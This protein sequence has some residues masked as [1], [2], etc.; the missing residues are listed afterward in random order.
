MK[1][2]KRFFA[3]IL[4]LLILCSFSLQL[5]RPVMAANYHLSTT[6]NYL[7]GRGR[8][9]MS[10][11]TF[12]YTGSRVNG[13]NLHAEKYATG[14]CS[15]LK[16]MGNGPYAGQ[17]AFCIQPNRISRDGYA[18]R[19]VR[20][21][22]AIREIY[23]LGNREAERVEHRVGLIGYYGWNGPGV[24]RNDIS[25]VATAHL[26][27]D[28]LGWK[29]RQGAYY[30]PSAAVVARMNAIRKQVNNFTVKPS[31]A[32]KHLRLRPG[33]SEVL[34]DSNGVLKEYMLGSGYQA[35]TDRRVAGLI[36]R[37]DGGDKLTVSADKNSAADTAVTFR[38]V[39]ADQVGTPL[40]FKG[41]TQGVTI[42]KV[43]Y[44]QTFKLTAEVEHS[45]RFELVKYDQ[46]NRI[47]D[48][49][50]VFELRDARDEPVRLSGRA[51][52]YRRAADTASNYVTEFRIKDGRVAVDDLLP[53]TYT[54]REL[55]VD[56]A[57]KLSKQTPEI[58]I[59]EGRSTALRFTNVLK[60]GHLKIRKIDASGK[61]LT[62]AVFEVYDS[63]ANPVALRVQDE[64][65]LRYTPE[66]DSDTVTSFTVNEE[67]TVR[68]LPIGSYTVREITPPAGYLL[69][70]TAEISATIES[71]RVTDAT[72]TNQKKTCQLEV[73]K[74]DNYG[75]PVDAPCRFEL[76]LD[77][78]PG[79]FVGKAPEYVYKPDAPNAVS[80]IYSVDGRLI[81]HQLP[82]GSYQLHELETGE[83]YVVNGYPVDFTVSEGQRVQNVTFTNVRRNGRLR[84][85]KVDEAD[86]PLSGVVFE[87]Y[88]DT[89]VPAML[90]FDASA[91]IY[92]YNP[93]AA[94]NQ[95]VTDAD[96][97]AEIRKLPAQ[98][99]FLI[100][101][102]AP[103]GYEIIDLSDDVF[104]IS[105]NVVYQKK[106]VNYPDRVPLI[107]KK[108][109]TSGTPV[110][111]VT[112]EIATQA[113]F[114]DATSVTTTADGTV[115]IDVSP[116]VLLYV[117]E[118][119]VPAPYLLDPEVKTLVPRSGRENILE[120]VNTVP[121]GTIRID[122]QDPSGKSLAGARIRLTLDRLTYPEQYPEWGDL[123]GIILETATPESGVL[124]VEDLP[125]GDYTVTEIVAPEGYARDGTEHKLSLDYRD[126]ATAELTAE[127]SLV[128]VPQTGII[129]LY[130]ADP[131]R[132]DAVAD[133]FSGAEFAVIRVTDSRPDSGGSGN[134]GETDK[135][136]DDSASDGGTEPDI[137][138]I[139]T[140][141]ASGMAVSPP[142]P[143]G[144][145]DIVERTAPNGYT[146]NETGLRVQLLAD[147][148]G[149]AV[150]GSECVI[151][152]SSNHQA[153]LNALNA[154][155]DEYNAMLITRGIEREPM[156]YFEARDLS[157]D[158]DLTFYN[159]SALGRI[160]LTKTVDQTEPYLPE[161]GSVAEAGVVFALYRGDNEAD[162]LITD[163]NGYA[164]SKLLPPGNYI[165]KQL[166]VADGLEK[167]EDQALTITEDRQLLS[168]EL[169]NRPLLTRLRIVKTDAETGKTLP[170]AGARFSLY[171]EDGTLLAPGGKEVF[172][173]DDE[174]VAVFPEKLRYGTY[175]LREI[176]APEGYYL[177]PDAED[178]L[179][180]INSESV[181]L[182]LSEVTVEVPNIPQKGRLM[183]E[184]TGDLFRGWRETVYTF[185]DTE[186]PLFEA[187]FEHGYLAGCEFGLRAAEDIVGADGTLHYAAGDTV[188]TV[189]TG[190]DGPTVFADVPLGHYELVEISAPPGYLVDPQV[191]PVEF[192]AQA[193]EV[194]FNI[195][196]KDSVNERV[197]Y[198]VRL[199]GKTFEEA[200]WHDYHLEAPGETLFGLRAVE[201]M[202][203]QGHV[204]PA[205][206]FVAFSGLDENLTAEFTAAFPGQYELCELRTHEA[207]Q[208]ADPVAVEFVDT[209]ETEP[210]RVVDIEPIAN[211][212][213]E[214]KI[215]VKK[216]SSDDEAV[217]L[218]GAVFKL[219]V[220]KDDA[221]VEIGEYESDSEGIIRVEHLEIG[222][223]Y[224]YEV[225]PP[226]GYARATEF[227]TVIIRPD[228]T[229]I[230]YVKVNAP[231]ETYI[232]KQDIGGKEI[233][234]AHLELRDA[235]G[236]LVESW[237]ST[238][239]PHR[240]FGLIEGARYELIERLAPEGYLKNE[241]S[242]FF[243]VEA[244]K[245]THVAMINALK[246]KEPDK[247]A[248]PPPVPKTPTPPTPPAPRVPGQPYIPR[249]GE[250][251]SAGR[252]AGAL[253]LFAAAV[254]F[255]LYTRKRRPAE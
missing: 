27:W 66:S 206:S 217:P 227:D 210:V 157:A 204:L 64:K 115:S 102:E 144:I 252:V 154:R 99:Y 242:V 15:L 103:D 170:V 131:L 134:A 129:R 198:R 108:R 158:A 202:E 77:G 240:I 43:P 126:A 248:A 255:R 246:S 10:A 6:W 171:T 21:R 128:N 50:A 176:A 117:R 62:G 94:S 222:E 49:H 33:E 226:A 195:V 101:T 35:N 251:E 156:P 160:E 234:G 219:Y 194:R 110:P 5:T 135:G 28:A 119:S 32:G 192:S 57:Y 125:P 224:L 96:G 58:T 44:S 228:H 200:A 123:I 168:L 69:A 140:T 236:E 11:Y 116:E 79:K 189:I 188:E 150:I 137:A 161:D 29:Q 241:E 65:T 142:L 80:N 254:G 209:T 75:F 229:E 225:K 146:L 83:K 56:T 91:G 76:L 12:D 245:P 38:N 205:G 130:K 124:T 1:K 122:K 74:I 163:E 46:H 201:A 9:D 97:L 87:L 88:A 22:D 127:V 3:V 18:V 145:Y 223:Y 40:G 67:M 178:I 13:W 247:P 177:D 196:E 23:A 173:T 138:A 112:F 31:F 211:E 172:E 20:L 61:P 136:R 175:R 19:A 106:I 249:T 186:Y 42:T 14:N 191:Y 212:L 153:A 159:H 147:P 167:L 34:I 193:A 214:G 151:P 207:Y 114:S 16:V 208:L 30:S 220:K 100:E 82:P 90:E 95:F 203:I 51:G 98:D 89:G 68:G 111:A 250:A 166:T 17:R 72:F 118:V 36:L 60:N 4:A 24:T 181:L 2:H 47:R 230:E 120:F 45:G 133:N 109:D 179:I 132:P 165:L 155:V 37:W 84:V 216:Q 199:A 164:T 93:S 85:S 59:R 174:G 183:L 221:M 197:V 54:V 232:S 190:A 48:I 235:A 238:D 53:G 63:D 25:Y 52:S 184:K 148:D 169:T 231:T 187:V 243:T 41:N 86:Q 71:D 39:V 107:V 55:A 105:H 215:I 244:G 73:K 143:L 152:L 253:L 139:L 121:Y 8:P 78:E 180:E 149:G 218:P 141:D 239:T 104:T 92:T 182:T 185:A 113:D 233:P 70:E 237:I 7:G 81:V 213:T 162:R 26:I